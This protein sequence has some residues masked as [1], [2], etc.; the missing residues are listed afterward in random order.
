[1]AGTGDLRRRDDTTGFLERH[2]ALGAVLT[3]ATLVVVG[4]LAGELAGGLLA[5][6]VVAAIQVITGGS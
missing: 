6:L 1:M 3:L 4:V 5:R 2:P